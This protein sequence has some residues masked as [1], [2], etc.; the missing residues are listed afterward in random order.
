MS[1]IFDEVNDLLAEVDATM[2]EVPE[3]EASESNFNESELQDIM[4]EIESL[5]KD[6]DVVALAEEEM[7]VE[8]PK[9]S[10]QD[11]IERELEMSLQSGEVLVEEAQPSIVSQIIETPS[12][13]KEVEE[14]VT[15]PTPTVLAFEK[16][17]TPTPAKSSEIS[18]E[19][20]GSM[21]LNLG[22]KIGQE[23]ANLS[24]DPVK[25][26]IVT[27]N[28]VELCINQENGCTVTMENGV[29]FT[30]PLTSTEAASKKKS[31]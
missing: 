16:K 4:A 9:T 27:M 6:S 5:E 8:P 25:G 13:V 17:S 23:T 15:A 7:I 21:N 24:I 10:L 30:I 18:F 14:V 26:M 28:G 11:K 12:A 2:E 19:A 20:T 1:D 31:A 22:F 3:A 29:K